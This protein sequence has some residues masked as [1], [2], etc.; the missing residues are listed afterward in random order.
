MA[1]PALSTCS[2]C[3]SDK[4]T[5]CAG[6]TGCGCVRSAQYAHHVDG[7]HKERRP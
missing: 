4:H 1:T 6:C 3:A 7:S 5:E 2:R